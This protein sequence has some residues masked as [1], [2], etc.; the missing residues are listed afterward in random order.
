V[1][2]VDV[3]DLSSSWSDG[4]AFCALIHSYFP[5]AFDFNQLDASDPRRNFQLAF[6]TA[7][8]VFS[9]SAPFY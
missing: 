6:D 4:L 7:Q 9:S 8:S 5:D 3:S 2:G 1:Q